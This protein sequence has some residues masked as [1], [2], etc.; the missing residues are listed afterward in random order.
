MQTFTIGELAKRAGVSVQAIRFYERKGIIAKAP[1]RCAGS[2]VG[3]AESPGYRQYDDDDVHEI[4]FIKRS[5]ELGFTLNEITELLNLRYDDAE[6][7]DEALALV[8]EKLADVDTRIRDLQR[9]KVALTHL[10]T[11]CRNRNASA[12][13][14]I[15]HALNEEN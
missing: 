6:K 9:I 8:G 12:A 13:C 4:R 2:I 10:S 3:S 15:I 5:Q 14:P 11:R 7:C 1:R